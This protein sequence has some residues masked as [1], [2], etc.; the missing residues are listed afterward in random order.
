M[1]G[2]PPKLS[3]GRGIILSG[4]VALLSRL[5]LQASWCSWP[6]FD[7]SSQGRLHK[8]T[9]G[10]SV[11]IEHIRPQQGPRDAMNSTNG[12][13]HARLPAAVIGRIALWRQS[14]LLSRT[15]AVSP[16]RPPAY[17]AVHSILLQGSAVATCR[18]CSCAGFRPERQ[19]RRCWTRA[20]QGSKR[21]ADLQIQ[22]L[23]KLTRIEITICAKRLRSASTSVSNVPVRGYPRLQNSLKHRLR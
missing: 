1:G 12:R 14:C 8:I 9:G 4:M 22:R 10:G 6:V 5:L 16:R 20:T 21:C 2:V 19:R 13:Q 7:R 11:A 23:S 17:N 3:L 15:E 18:L